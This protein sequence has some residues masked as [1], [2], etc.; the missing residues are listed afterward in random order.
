[1]KSKQKAVNPLRQQY[2]AILRTCLRRHNSG[3]TIAYL[4]GKLILAQKSDDFRQ[5][6]TEAVDEALR[7]EGI[8]KAN[9]ESI[10]VDTVRYHYSNPEGRLYSL[11]D[12]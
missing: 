2:I 6:H 3:A 7:H 9:S 5:V 1:M 12:G 11:I 8:G 10:D 4:L